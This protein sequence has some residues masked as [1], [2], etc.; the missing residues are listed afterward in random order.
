[1]FTP[2][3]KQTVYQRV[4]E[5]EIEKGDRDYAKKVVEKAVDGKVALT[6]TGQVSKQMMAEVLAQKEADVEANRQSGSAGRAEAKAKVDAFELVV[7]KLKTMPE[8]DEKL[9]QKVDKTQFNS[10]M[11]IREKWTMELEALI[12]KF[13]KLP[14]SPKHHRQEAKSILKMFDDKVNGHFKGHIYDQIHSAV[15]KIAYE[16]G[17]SEK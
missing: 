11:R 3:E 17:S 8:V 14:F 4:I 13:D 2:S 16:M 15:E 1:M 6:L 12:V 10:Q 7:D 9:A 5:F